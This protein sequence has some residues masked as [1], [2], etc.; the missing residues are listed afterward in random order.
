MEEIAHW[1]QVDRSLGFYDTIEFTILHTIGQHCTLEFQRR[2]KKLH[3][4]MQIFRKR[5]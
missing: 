5:E 4:V 2:I 1:R 3:E